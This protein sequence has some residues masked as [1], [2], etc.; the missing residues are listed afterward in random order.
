M[1][2]RITLFESTWAQ[3]DL[4]KGNSIYITSS[5][6]YSFIIL[7]PHPILQA[8]PVLQTH[9]VLQ[10]QP[11]KYFITGSFE[12]FQFVSFRF[13]SDLFWLSIRSFVY[14]FSLILILHNNCLTDQSCLKTY[15]FIQT[16]PVFRAL[17]RMILPNKAILSYRHVLKCPK[18]NS[19]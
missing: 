4:A 1:I 6:C 3:A 2:C 14:S 11:A 15:F 18:N 7:Q 8:H 10:A 19:I 5:S 16:F 13:R 12:L 17:N 9:H